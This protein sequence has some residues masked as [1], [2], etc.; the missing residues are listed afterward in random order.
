MIKVDVIWRHGR[1]N[2]C[3]RNGVKRQDQRNQAGARSERVS[4]QRA[5]DGITGEP[6]AHDAQ[7]DDDRQQECRARKPSVEPLK[8]SCRGIADGLDL[9]SDSVFFK[10]VDWQGKGGIHPRG[11][12]PEN[13]WKAARIC[14]S[15]DTRAYQSSFDLQSGYLHRLL[16]E[17]SD[18]FPQSKTP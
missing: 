16:D 11:N 12:L 2:V 8:T 15:I 17:F 5:A 10:L 4:K 1:F 14:S 6:F 3:A 13:F 18:I 7:G 9:V